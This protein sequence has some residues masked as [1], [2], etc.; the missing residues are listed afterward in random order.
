MCIRDSLANDH[1]LDASPF[2]FSAKTMTFA[3][4]NIEQSLKEGPVIASV[5]YTFDPKNP[6]PHLVV[7]RGIKDG[8]IYY[9]DPAIGEGSISISTFKKSWKKRYIEVRPAV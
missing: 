8:E 4:S 1:G 5:H 2:D 9:N 6:I 3:F 7:I